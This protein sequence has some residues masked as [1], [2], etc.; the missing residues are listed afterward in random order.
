[1]DNARFDALAQRLTSALSRRRSLGLL[2]LLG[3]P[4][5]LPASE[6]D[7][8]KKCAPCQKRKHG[9]CKGKKPDGTPCGGSRICH[10]GRCR[11]PEGM[12]PC[13]NSDCI[14]QALCCPGGRICGEGV[15]IDSCGASQHCR[16]QENLE[17]VTMCGFAN[18]ACGCT[19]D[20][21]C[22][23]YGPGS[24]CGSVAG[25][26]IC[27]PGVGLCMLPCDD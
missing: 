12:K 24:F 4:P 6:T 10:D 2:A 1:M 21:D 15:E 7:A 13:G 5:V 23:A 11:C 27:P 17:G 19:R 3:L 14:A 18:G 16:C 20:A 8:K 9:T 25:C 22:V 26:T